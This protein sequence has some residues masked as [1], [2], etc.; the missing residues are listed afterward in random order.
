M[1]KS[2]SGIKEADI[3]PHIHSMELVDKDGDIITFS[4]RLSAG[5]EYNL[6]P[7]TVVDAMM[8]YD[9]DFKVNFYNVHRC[10]LLVDDKEY[11]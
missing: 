1:K 10:A 3:K 5:N 9:E 7:D 6:K 8:K 4:M 11:I 2:K